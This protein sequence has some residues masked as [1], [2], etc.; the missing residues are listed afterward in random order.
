MPLKIAL[1]ALSLTLAP[2]LAL[3]AGCGQKQA[4]SCAEG[5]MWDAAS[6]SCVKQV[7]G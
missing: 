3:A 2:T 1:T 6:K 5:M 4:Q 7:T